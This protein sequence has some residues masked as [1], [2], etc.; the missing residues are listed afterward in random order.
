MPPMPALFAFA[1]LATLIDKANQSKAV[2]SEDAKT[3]YTQP[4]VVPPV[5]ADA[6]EPV[7]KPGRVGRKDGK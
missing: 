5:P 2:A 4:A 6:P 3:I 1:H 7:A